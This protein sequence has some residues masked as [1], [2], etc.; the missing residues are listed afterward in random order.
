MEYFVDPPLNLI[1]KTS[2]PVIAL[3]AGVVAGCGVAIA[4]FYAHVPSVDVKKYPLTATI[5]RI[6][7]RFNTHA[8]KELDLFFR[9]LDSFFRD[10]VP[11]SDLLLAGVGLACALEQRQAAPSRYVVNWTKIVVREKKRHTRGA[12]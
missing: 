9:T 8:P 11:E 7:A 3:A 4:H 6:L 1:A 2:T 5:V 10:E 12:I